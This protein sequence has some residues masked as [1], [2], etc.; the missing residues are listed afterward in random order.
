MTYRQQKFTYTCDEATYLKLQSLSGKSYFQT[1]DFQ[2][3]ITN[4]ISRTYEK[5]NGKAIKTT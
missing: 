1:K 2:A 3:I 5:S 4:L